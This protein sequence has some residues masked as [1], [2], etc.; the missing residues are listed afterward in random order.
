VAFLPAA[1]FLSMQEEAPVKQVT[2]VKDLIRFAERRKGGSLN[3][4]EGVLHGSVNPRAKGVTLCWM[5]TPDAILSAGKHGHNVLIGHESLY[6]PYNIVRKGEGPEGCWDW[7][8]NQRRR[9]LLDKY[10]LTFLRL[11][12]SVDDICILDDFAT[13]LGLGNSV[14]RHGITRVYE[15]PPCTFDELVERVK[16]ATG[17]ARVRIAPTRQLPRRITRVGLPW[18]GLGLFVNVSYQQSLVASGCDAFVA[19]ESDNYGARFA[20]EN[21]IP[22]IETDH[23]VSEN[24]GLAHFTRM[25]AGEFPGVPFRFYRNRRVWQVR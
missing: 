8:L 7:P 19:G 9:A 15:C 1:L 16:K 22:M 4:D 21:G 18:G 17:M 5:A 25:L 20:L 12:G 24:P 10:G 14:V 2:R 11:H 13:M 6:Y 23:E 3:G